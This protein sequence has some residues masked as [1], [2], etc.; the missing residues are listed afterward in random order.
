[1]RP[2]ISIILFLTFSHSFSQTTGWR[3]YGGDE[4]GQRFAD[5]DQITP[6]NVGDLK[7]V[8]TF[9]TGELER[10]EGEEYLLEK[11]AFEATPIVIDGTMY[12]PTPG[13]Q[14]FALNAETGE[15]QWQFDPQIDL[16]RG[17]F[18]EFTCRGVS[19]WSDG[20]NQRL[21]M[22][23]VDGRLFS[24]DASSGKAD[25]D[26]G[27][28]GYIDLKT[29]VGLVQVTSAPAIFKNIVIVGTSIGDN[30]RTHDSRGVVR[31]F[32]IKDG[33][34]LWRFDP[35]PTRPED[36]AFDSWENGSA[37]R[38][39]AANVWATISV[40]TENDLVF[41]PTSSPSPDFYGGERPGNNDYANSVV[42]LKASNG[43]Y[44]WHFQAVHHD[45]WDYDIPA[46]PLLFDYPGNDGPVPAVAIGTKM[47]HIF[48]LNRLT[49]EAILPYKE[50]AVPSST[51][52]G[53]QASPTQPF[54]VMPL[55]LGIQNITGDHIWAPMEE[56]LTIAQKDFSTRRYE[57]V[58][59]P[60]SLEGTVVAPGNIGGIH[61]G[62]MSFDPQRNLLVTNINRIAHLI[63][64]LP[65][66]EPGELDAYLNAIRNDDNQ[67]NPETNR[68]LGTP[69]YMSRMV[70]AKAS[71]KGFWPYT[72]PPWGT[73]LAIDIKTGEKKW[74]NP[75][76]FM[77]DPSQNPDFLKYGAVNLG[78][79]CLTS[80]G[81]I[82]VAGT[83]D[84]HLRAIDVVSGE[85]LWQYPLPASG[86]AT[87]MTYFLNGK[88]YI[89]I[90]A[91]GHGKNRLTKL[92]DYIM[93]FAL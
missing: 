30:N 44:Q 54:P 19:Y 69:Y 52:Q 59:T 29:G 38:T 89:V 39:G 40:D 62:G 48:V 21:L 86:I 36:P 42:A 85:L 23:T 25:V 16:K 73:I 45:I 77:G 56:E 76:G 7:P 55:P 50:R 24:V 78:G 68:M 13:N 92:G 20:K 35:I 18:S 31:A 74:E 71:E 17:D 41:L 87:P 37:L 15:K 12:F 2:F 82:F 61:W 11:A 14:L 22:G 9:R 81:L 46:Q 49:G 79:T 6:G 58:F 67:I 84:N 80:T 32:R 60:P 27:E 33:Q 88:Q 75:L 51:V 8:W 53:E 65:R 93:V 26:F 10:Y 66:H 57:G 4:G 70:Y 5:L 34:E 91:G 28:K 64:L 90:A 3:Y 1:M 63:Q 83:P 47:G 72:Q 43:E